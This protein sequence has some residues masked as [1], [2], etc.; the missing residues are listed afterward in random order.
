[1]FTN[2]NRV[3]RKSGLARLVEGATA[4]VA[5]DAGRRDNHQGA[6]VP[7]DCQQ[8]AGVRAVIVAMSFATSFSTWIE[9]ATLLTMPTETP[10]LA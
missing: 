6:D 10:I 5:I 3:E 8:L 2:R 9:G 1:V 7:L 4:R